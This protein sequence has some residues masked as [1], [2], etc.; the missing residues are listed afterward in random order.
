MVKT[1]L[2]FNARADDK[3]PSLMNTWSFDELIYCMELVMVEVCRLPERWETS[4][5]NVIK[6]HSLFCIGEWYQLNV[7]EGVLVKNT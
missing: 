3:V 1:F 6:D 2:Q 4:G 5:M 7:G